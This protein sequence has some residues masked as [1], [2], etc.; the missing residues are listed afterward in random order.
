MPATAR[1]CRWK[2]S[3]VGGTARSSA[4]PAAGTTTRYTPSPRGMT[5][6]RSWVLRTSV[7]DGGDGRRIRGHLHL[8]QQRLD[9]GGLAGEADAEQLAHRAAAA[10]AADEVARAQLRAV[11]QLGGHPVV[12]LAQPDQLAA[13]PDLDADLGG[14]LGQQAVG[15]GLRDAEDVRVRGVQ[16]LRRRLADAGEE[17]AER[18]LLAE[19]EEPLQQAALVHDLDAARVQAERADDP[20]RLRV[21]LQHEHVHA[22]QPQLAGQ[23]QAGRSAAGHDHVN[24]EAPIQQGCIRSA[25]PRSPVARTRVAT[26]RFR[27]FWPRPAI[28][29]HDPGLAASPPVRYR[30]KVEGSAYSPFRRRAGQPDTGRLGPARRMTH[31]TAPVLMPSWTEYRGPR[32]VRR[33]GGGPRARRR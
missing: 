21:L 14:V 10:V 7:V 22:V 16:P 1:S 13:A 25:A 12:V 17:A 9:R 15:D 20:G 11:G 2:S 18:V 33:E 8:A 3:R 4:T 29:R 30:L 6:N 5:P 28:L 31:P 24:H 19:R 26:L 27:R 23:H 32:R